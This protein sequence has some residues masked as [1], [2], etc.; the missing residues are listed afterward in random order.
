MSLC[1]A[2]LHQLAKKTTF[3]EC[4]DD[5]I[6]GTSLNWA[7]LSQNKILDCKVHI[8]LLQHS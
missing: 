2:F 6:G 3:V 7:I 4:K 8:S 1:L 5:L